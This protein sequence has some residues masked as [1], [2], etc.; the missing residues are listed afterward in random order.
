[1]ES[2]ESRGRFASLLHSFA[3]AVTG[4]AQGGH[5]SEQKR[6]HYG[7]AESE[8]QNPRVRSDFQSDRRLAWWQRAEQDTAA[9]QGEQKADGAAGECQQPALGQELAHDSPARRSNRQAYG[10]LS[11]ARIST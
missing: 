2:G 11:A 4:C 5:Q 6:A 10:N 3:Y 7:H 8:G 1:M 9:P